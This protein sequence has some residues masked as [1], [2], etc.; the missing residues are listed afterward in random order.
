MGGTRA[1][2]Y[3]LPP[4]WGRAAWWAVHSIDELIA[5]GDKD[6]VPR[7]EI[8]DPAQPS[9]TPARESAALTIPPEPVVSATA[10]PLPGGGC[11]LPMP[12]TYRASATVRSLS[13]G[14]ARGL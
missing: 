11:L 12:D 7:R 1:V 2:V 3:A 10:V 8:V 5:A 4:D 6:D 13:T 14:A 9:P